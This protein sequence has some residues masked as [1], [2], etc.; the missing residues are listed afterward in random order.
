MMSF[1][2]R[3]GV[4]LLGLLPW[5]TLAAAQAADESSAPLPTIPLPQAAAPLPAAD[6]ATD[7]VQLPS[8][9]VTARRRE[10]RA[11]DVPI[12]MSVLD[13]GALGEAGLTLPTDIQERVPALV[14]MSASARLTQYTIRGLGST[15]QN[16][17]MESSVGL[18]LDGVY[19][20]RQGLSMFDLVDLD[21]V[22]VLRGPQGT[23]FGKNTTA[24]AVSVVTKAPQHAYDSTLE[25]TYGND[26]LRQL[27][28][29]VTGEI[30]GDET[31][32]GR[33]TG[34]YTGRDGTIENLYDGKDLNNRNKY[35]LRGQLLWTPAASLSGRF[36][37]EYAHAH[38]NCCVYPL[39]IYRDKVRARDE[40]MEYTRAPIDP[41][42]RKTDTDTRTDSLVEQ[43]AVSAEFNW[44]LGERHRLTSITAY[45]DWWFT[46]YSDDATSLKLVPE[47]GTS[48]AQHQF[49]EELRLSSKTDLFDSVFGLYYLRQRINSF[50]RNI[51]GRDMVGWTFGGLIRENLLP[52]ATESNFGPVLY[53]AVPPA[54]LDGMTIRTKAH[55]VS[56]SAAAFGSVDWHLTDKL[57]LTTGLRYTHEWKDA[58]VARHR[59]GGCPNCTVLS[60]VSPI[61]AAL[62]LEDLTV[63]GLLDAVAGG[64][65][66]RTTR[67]DE[68]NWSGQL[69]LSYRW[70][71]NLLAYAS[72]ARGY[73][74]GGINL[75]VTGDSVQP[76][77]DPEEATS[78]EIGAKAML[79]R[80]AQV[81]LALYQTDVHDYQALTFD[82]EQTLIPN[83]RQINLLNVGKVRL[84]GAELE[85][86]ALLARGL[87]A[88]AGVAYNQ[89]IA[90]DFP[91]APNED[92]GQNT[93]D[94]SGEDLYNA[95][96]WTA[97]AGLEY[98]RP[99]GPLEGYGGVDYS[100]RSGY[101][102][103][104]EHGKGSYIHSYDLTNLRLGVRDAAQ[105]WDVSAWVRNVFDEDYLAAVYA[106]YGVG[107]YGAT[108]ADPR[109]Y[110]VTLR[111]NFR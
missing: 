61:F 53:L 12:S 65:Y 4:C 17:G 87:A 96:R 88:R 77:F 18:F 86:Q 68:G 57:D 90:E 27:R 75:G 48:N 103:T 74:S 22:E 109:T 43:S 14:V 39:V 56:D 100:F 95:P 25:G 36:I 29:T 63:D 44:D 101:W 55:Q 16:D 92:T 2:Q 40:F 94:L 108:A 67:Y 89:A 8:V 71:P 1:R 34:Y 5:P 72:A 15:S 6:P 102:A 93:K 76:T 21:R 52:F 24:G 59:S 46:P 104:V 30:F 38:E 31:L 19:L 62:G 73:K 11:L 78:Y 50:E 23:L 45:R 107:D 3:A 98:S 80:R 79:G 105:V 110:G 20:G 26:E 58:A 35:G 70:T 84:R 97:T 32:A 85:A 9:V 28:G 51:L 33:L 60:L 10:E 82:E 99:I 66:Q 54:T 42:Q 64:E 81:S 13:G 111:L 7:D 69:A 49:S 47:T 41:Y 91:D 83:P 106:L 37:A